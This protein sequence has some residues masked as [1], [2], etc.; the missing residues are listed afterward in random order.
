MPMLQFPDGFAW[1][2]ATAAYQVE[3]AADEGGRG[4]SIWDAFSK[5]PGKTLNGDTGDKAVDHYHLYK[6]NARRP[7][8]C[9]RTSPRR[10]MALARAIRS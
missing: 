5:T 10:P 2:A 3:G 6:E 9:A 4:L 7:L 1:G 8:R